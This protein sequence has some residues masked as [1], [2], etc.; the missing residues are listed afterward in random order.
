MELVDVGPAKP[1]S[2][3]PIGLNHP[4]ELDALDTE[5]VALH[6]RGNPER[7]DSSHPVGDP[8]NSDVHPV[9]PQR[10]GPTPSTIFYNLAIVEEAPH[11]TTTTTPPRALATPPQASANPPS[12]PPPDSTPDKPKLT[13]YRLLVVSLTTG[14]G[15]A[16]AILTYQGHTFAPTTLGWIFGIVITLFLA[17]LGW[18][19]NIRSYA[20]LRYWLFERDYIS[21]VCWLLWK[22]FITGT[23]PA[24]RHSSLVY[25]CRFI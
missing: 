4:L 25:T 6:P 11:P 13:G 1:L 19:E 5:E 12:V 22:G 16:Q 20:N 24:F 2:P 15:T 18:Y 17:W 21:D 3:S 9:V 14:F 23:Q 7:Q 8:P 10:P